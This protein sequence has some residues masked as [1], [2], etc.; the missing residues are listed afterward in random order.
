MKFSKMSKKA[1]KQDIKKRN[2]KIR[3]HLRRRVKPMIDALC[4]TDMNKDLKKIKFK[5]NR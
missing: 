1:S 5:K 4:G 3:L 2:E